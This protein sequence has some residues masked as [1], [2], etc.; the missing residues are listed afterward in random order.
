M[1]VFLRQ[2]KHP[3]LWMFTLLRYLSLF[4]CRSL[5]HLLSVLSGLPQ[6]Y[7]WVPSSVNPGPWWMLSWM[8]QNQVPEGPRGP[9]H[10][11]PSQL[12]LNMQLD[13]HPCKKSQLLIVLRFIPDRQPHRSQF[14]W[15]HCS[16][17]PLY[18]PSSGPFIKVQPPNLI[19]REIFLNLP[20]NHPS[21]PNFKILCTPLPFRGNLKKWQILW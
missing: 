16:P 7:E 10:S 14:H 8:C 1:T 15:P 18:K 13:K 20:H 11:S 3:L 5:L 4:L 12:L 6:C 2:I 9:E 17:A 19:S 21:S